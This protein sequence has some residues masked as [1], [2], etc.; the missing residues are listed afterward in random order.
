MHTTL[1]STDVLADDL[2]NPSWLIADCR[3][4]LN[5]AAWKADRWR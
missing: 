4:N 5:D 3:Y 2:A 1:I